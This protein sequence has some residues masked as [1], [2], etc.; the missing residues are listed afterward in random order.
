MTADQLAQDWPTRWPRPSALTNRQHAAMVK[1][2]GQDFGGRPLDEITRE[3]AREW[4][5]R[6]PSRVRFVRTMLNDA[7]RDGFATRN[8]WASLRIATPRKERY[9]PSTEEIEELLEATRGDSVLYGRIKFAAFT[10]LRLGEQLA[11]TYADLLSGCEGQVRVSVSKQLRVDGELAKP[12]G[13][14]KMRYALVPAKALSWPSTTKPYVKRSKDFL[15]PL[16]RSEH[17][18]EWNVLRRSL[19]L[20]PNFVWHSLRHH[21]ATWFLDQGASFEDVAIQ[22]GHDDQGTQVRETYG[23]MSREKALDRLEAIVGG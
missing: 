22:L 6:H 9:F 19:D 1:Q 2:W 11:L 10:G 18:R 16:T 7:I 4:G 8:V 15:W 5:L 3:E 21:A 17:V 20:P 13:K 14:I 23:H 12:K